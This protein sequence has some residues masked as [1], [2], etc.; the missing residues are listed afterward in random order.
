M[1]MS[2]KNSMSR[3]ARSHEY[4][5]YLQYTEV[6]RWS[7]CAD[8][9]LETAQVNHE[10][11]THINLNKFMQQSR[12]LKA[13]GHKELLTDVVEMRKTLRLGR[14]SPGARAGLSTGSDSHMAGSCPAARA[15]ARRRVNLQ[16]ISRSTAA[17]R[18]EQS[19][20]RSFQKPEV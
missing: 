11:Y 7:T 15:W 10:I 1:P 19:R 12:L 20:H 17:P 4:N 14:V 18:R 8:S 6:K 9:I 3:R 2:R 16:P 13:P 5:P